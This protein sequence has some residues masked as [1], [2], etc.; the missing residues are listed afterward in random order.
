MERWFGVRRRRAQIRAK[1]M[2]GTG[3]DRRSG[4]AGGDGIAQPRP[5]TARAGCGGG[6]WQRASDHHQHSRS[7]VPKHGLRLLPCCRAPA[8]SLF[9]IPISIYVFSTASLESMQKFEGLLEFL[10]EGLLKIL[11]FKLTGYSY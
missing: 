4:D 3:R 6:S 11:P 7:R 10:G 5:A 1:R 2:A 9:T 8:P